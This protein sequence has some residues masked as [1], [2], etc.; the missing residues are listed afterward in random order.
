MTQQS[1]VRDEHGQKTKV[2]LT[3]NFTL[4]S[5]IQEFKEKYPESMYD[6]N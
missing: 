1:L 5:Y 4:R 2:V 3:P 6:W